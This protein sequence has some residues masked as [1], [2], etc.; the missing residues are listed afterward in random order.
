[1]SYNA[2]F[3]QLI[4][5]NLFK[6]YLLD[7]HM[8]PLDSDRILVVPLCLAWGIDRLLPSSISPRL[9]SDLLESTHCLGSFSQPLFLAPS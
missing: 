8:Q 7:F 6:L 5:H 2:I 4:T 3:T 9:R 1:M